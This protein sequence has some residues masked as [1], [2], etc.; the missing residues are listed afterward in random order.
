MHHQTVYSVGY[1]NLELP[2]LVDLLKQHEIEYLI[3]V[4][5]SPYSRFNPNY[6]RAPLEASL[7]RDGIR[8]V[9][10]GDLLGGLPDDAD[11]YVDG[12]VDYDLVEQRP[13]FQRGIERLCKASSLGHRVCLFCSEAA[14]SRCHRSK[15]IGQVLVARDVPVEHILHDGTLMNQQ[16]VIHQLTG[17]Q[18]S[19]FGDGFT[20]RK[21]YG[22]VQADSR[23]GGLNE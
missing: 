4:R 12:K 1:G 21:R 5:S 15:L 20:S 16:A 10:M 19:L 22:Q 7:R 8:Y 3:D 14:P 18:K 13:Q 2:K 9:F 6:S 23:Q 11:C 17:G